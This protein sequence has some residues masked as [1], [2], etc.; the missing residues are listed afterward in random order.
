MSSQ[1]GAMSRERLIRGLG[2]KTGPVATGIV[3][4]FNAGS[5]TTAAAR[6]RRAFHRNRFL[7]G[8]AHG[9]RVPLSHELG[10]EK[11]ERAPAGAVSGR[12]RRL[13]VS[14]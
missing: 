6:L 13:P 3:S 10:I 8:Y 1:V 7:A 9:T 14:G 2:V 11:M 12:A 5:A 4:P